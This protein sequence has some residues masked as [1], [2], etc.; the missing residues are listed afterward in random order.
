VREMYFTAAIAEA[1]D[2]AMATDPS[3]IVLGED[4]KTGPIGGT[5][6][7]FD[8]Y[9]PDRVR[10]TPITEQT[11]VGSCVGAAASGLRPV[12][13]M[14]FA[15]FFYVAMDQLGNQA[16]RLRYMSGGQIE[17]PIVFMSGAGPAGSLAAQ[18]SENPHPLVMQLAGLKLVVPSTP[19]DAKGLMLA[20]IRDP[21]PVVY[22]IDLMLTG[23]KGPVPEEPYE[24]PLGSADVKRVGSDITLVAIG[25][26]VPLALE[27]AD[28]LEAE[29]VSVEVVDPRSLVPLDWPTIASSIAKT[30]RLIVADPA[31]RTCGAAAELLSRA[32]ETNWD[33]LKARPRRVTWADVPI[34]FSPPL[35][36]AA[37]VTRDDILA[38]VHETL[39]AAHAPALPA[40]NARR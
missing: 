9:G 18:H 2:H 20:S 25:S 24:I 17:L 32:V 3:V 34:P 31:R 40:S 22:L 30:G 38:T 11:I 12:A 21:N 6:G 36:T 37:I 15:S 7:L 23:K 4:V 13:D 27:V 33:D 35:E 14:M 16:A 28:E 5:K 8:K 29:G 1:L 10:N 39:G 19:A 26:L